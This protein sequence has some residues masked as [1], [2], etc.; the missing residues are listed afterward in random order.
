MEK[1]ASSGVYIFESAVLGLF[2][3]THF[4][5][6]TGSLGCGLTSQAPSPVSSPHTLTEPDRVPASAGQGSGSKAHAPQSPGQPGRTQRNEGAASWAGEQ[7]TT[8]L[9]AAG[10]AGPR[11]ATAGLSARAHVGGGWVWR[12]RTPGS[13]SRRC[14]TPRLGPGREQQGGGWKAAGSSVGQGRVGGASGPTVRPR[15]ARPSAQEPGSFLRNTLS[16]RFFILLI[17]DEFYF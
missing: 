1:A 2:P 4:S 17:A 13:G 16:V 7:E 5:G 10:Q 12:G 3:I 15:G 11:A 9:G 8:A 14:V 6:H